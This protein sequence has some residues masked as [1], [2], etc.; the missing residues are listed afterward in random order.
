MTAANQ[1]NLYEDLDMLLERLDSSE[2]TD[3][4]IRV[5]EMLAYNPSEDFDYTASHTVRRWL[6]DQQRA[7]Q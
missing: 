4:L 5:L 6:R 7:D 2:Y 3:V 1:Q